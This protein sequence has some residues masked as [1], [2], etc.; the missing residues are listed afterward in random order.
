MNRSPPLTVKS[1]YT[2][3]APTEQKGKCM[4]NIQKKTTVT[5]LND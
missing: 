5:K 3:N 2:F 4:S 1:S